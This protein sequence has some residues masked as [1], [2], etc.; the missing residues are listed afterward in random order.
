[1]HDKKKGEDMVENKGNEK[2]GKKKSFF[3]KLA[4]KL[5]KKM[6]EKAETA[7]SCCGDNPKGASCCS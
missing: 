7:K 3:G 6:K 4:E 5:D 1:M 2:S